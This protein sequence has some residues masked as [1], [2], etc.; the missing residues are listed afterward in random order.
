MDDPT[1]Y[2][3]SQIQKCFK[4]ASDRLWEEPRRNTESPRTVSNI[5]LDITSEENHV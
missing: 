2:A 1:E 3:I 4:E 5:C